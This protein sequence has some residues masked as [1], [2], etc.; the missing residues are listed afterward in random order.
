MY[1]K[2]HQ[3]LSSI[4]KMHAKENWFLF[5]CLTVGKCN[6]NIHRLSDS[7]PKRTL[8]E[9][10]LQQYPRSNNAIQRLLQGTD[11]QTDRQTTSRCFMLSSMN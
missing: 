5:F 2:K 1:V 8:A 6:N 9:F 11:R 7:R 4:K 10:S 3:F